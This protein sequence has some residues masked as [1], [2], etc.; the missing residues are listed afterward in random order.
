MLGRVAPAGLP[1]RVADRVYRLGL[2]RVLLANL[3]AQ[4]GI[5]LTGGVVRLSGSGL[6]CPS[7]PQCVPGSYRPVLTQPQGWHKDIEFGNRLLTYVLV[8]AAVAAF[9]AVWRH[10]QLTGVSPARPV[11]WLAAVPVLGI[12]AQAVIGGVSV[13]TDLNPWVVA[14]HFLC[15]AA[16]VAAST[17]LLL[18]VAPSQ[19]TAAPA[20]APSS[21]GVGPEVRWLV[22]AVCAV[23][24][25][26]LVLGTIVTGSGPHS[27]DATSRRFGF[28][29]RTVSWLH[30]DAVW[31]FVGLV[32]AL[33][34]ALRLTGA[35]ALA[36]RRSL[37]LMAVTLGQGLIGY[38]Q[39]FTGV[40]AVLVAA[41]MLGASLL[42]VAVTVTAYAVLHPAGVPALYA[43]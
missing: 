29:V 10:L 43:R 27:G 21:Q 1:A 30:A 7:W 3:V 33:I 9:L 13:L 22:V 25:A 14:L 24:T 20:G 16:L 11:L 12:P 19:V 39:Y 15:S 36:R 40:P 5:I 41:H 35:P 2:R 26:V 17:W 6:G 31:L 18:W 23:A 4:I 37:Q 42:V 28:D 8:V 38:V 34:L 32:F